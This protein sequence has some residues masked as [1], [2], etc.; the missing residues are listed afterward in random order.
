MVFFYLTNKSQSHIEI[1]QE[2]MTVS[3]IYIRQDR[4]CVKRT[5]VK[6]GHVDDIESLLVKMM[7]D[8]KSKLNLTLNLYTYD[9]CEGDFRDV[10]VAYSSIHGYV[11]LLVNTI[12]II[13]YC[14]DK[15][16][17]VAVCRLLVIISTTLHFFL[18]F[19]ITT[20]K[21]HCQE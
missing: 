16:L 20:I 21:Q 13:Y 4:E 10:I 2:M 5:R 18:I 15:S 8:A 9:Y 11:S 17:C 12:I 7:K 3:R 14:T 6:G 1:Y 19:D